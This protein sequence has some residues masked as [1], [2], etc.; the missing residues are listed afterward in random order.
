MQLMLVLPT[1]FPPSP[2]ITTQP[3]TPPPSSLPPPP[4]ARDLYDGDDSS[5]DEDNIIDCGQE[6]MRKEETRQDKVACIAHNNKHA[7]QTIKDNIAVEQ[8]AN[9]HAN[10]QQGRIP[11]LVEVVQVGSSWERDNR[12]RGMLS[13]NLY[14]HASE[15]AVYPAH[16]GQRMYEWEVLDERSG[17]HPSLNC[18]WQRV[19]PRG[20]PRTV[21]EAKNL[22]EL[23][24]QSLTDEER[25][26]VWMLLSEFYR[27]SRAFIPKQ[28]DHVMNWV[29]NEYSY[30]RCLRHPNWISFT[31]V[32]ADPAALNLQNTNQHNRGAG[33][34]QPTPQQGFDI[35]AWA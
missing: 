30:A 32:P 27:M 23:M 10:L 8:E 15:N 12:F 2:T 18:A 31:M 19:S 17:T 33:I 4:K 35:D 1:T 13:R 11:D 25:F 20:F 26:G 9:R 5:E 7:K 29:A 22:V 3:A 24:E 28:R 34:P 6:S 21:Q 14:Y 16:A